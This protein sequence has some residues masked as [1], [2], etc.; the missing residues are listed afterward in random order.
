MK[1]K[2]LFVVLSTFSISPIFAGYGS[3]KDKNNND[4][5][6]WVHQ[7]LKNA[8]ECENKYYE[9]EGKD[10]RNYTPLEKYNHEQ[11]KHSAYF[12][13]NYNLNTAEHYKNKK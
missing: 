3:D 10:T 4:N 11:D 13:W 5:Q 2:G 7:H 12:C 8:K 9:L 6:Y 1:F